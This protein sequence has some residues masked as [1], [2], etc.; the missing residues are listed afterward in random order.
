MCEAIIIDVVMGQS[1]CGIGG[2]VFERVGMGLEENLRLSSRKT[3]GD[4]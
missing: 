1:A 3:V 2:W 4:L